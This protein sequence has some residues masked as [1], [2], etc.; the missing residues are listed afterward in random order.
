MA[1][2][3]EVPV[4]GAGAV[5]VPNSEAPEEVPQA[6]VSVH[7]QSAVTGSAARGSG[8]SGSL[9]AERDLRD[10]HADCLV[11][12]TFEGAMMLYLESQNGVPPQWNE[13]QKVGFALMHEYTDD[14]QVPP[15]DAS[16]ARTRYLSSVYGEVGEAI[17]EIQIDAAGFDGYVDKQATQKKILKDVFSK[18]DQWFRSG[19]L[20]SRDKDGYFYF[21]DRIGDTFRWK[22]E[23]VA[24]SEVAHAFQGFSHIEEVNVYGVD[25]PGNDGRA[26]MVAI[27]TKS[28]IDLANLYSHLKNSL[29]SYAC[30]LYTSPSPRDKRQS[31]MPSSA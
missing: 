15:Q 24:T 9:P 28:D 19:D 14:P 21:I 5:E 26:G 18:D 20:L 25:L 27:V 30:L 23:N 6:H 1:A 10:A 3:S 13:F 4:I 16:G 12:S 29:P 8:P 11:A 17:G 31:R 7:D 22:G 2:T